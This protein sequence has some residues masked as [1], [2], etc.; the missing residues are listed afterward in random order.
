M[1]VAKKLIPFPQKLV[2]AS[3][4]FVASY[5]YPNSI[6]LEEGFMFVERKTIFEF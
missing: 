5:H 6:S 4:M 2:W 3:G 1:F